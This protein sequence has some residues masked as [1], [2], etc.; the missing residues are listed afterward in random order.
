MY[1]SSPQSTRLVA[2]VEEYRS[3]LVESRN[4]WKEY[5]P[6]LIPLLATKQALLQA[7]TLALVCFLKIRSHLVQI[8]NQKKRI[9]R[10]HFFSW[11]GSTSQNYEDGGGRN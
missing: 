7:E 6:A 10:S 11:Q 3:F 8:Q 4:H 2:L 9:M 5:H 1:T